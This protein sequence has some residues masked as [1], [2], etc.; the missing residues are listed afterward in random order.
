ME[1]INCIRTRG[2]MSRTTC[3]LRRKKK[4]ASGEYK[5]PEC[6]DCPGPEPLDERKDSQGGTAMK[7][8]ER[9]ESNTGRQDKHQKRPDVFEPCSRCGDKPCNK[10]TWRRKWSGG[11]GLCFPCYDIVRKEEKGEAP[12]AVKKRKSVDPPTTP[13]AAKPPEPKT[14][15]ST[16]EAPQ[17]V[18]DSAVQTFPLGEPG[19]LSVT[20]ATLP[21][22]TAVLLKT[23]QDPEAARYFV[24]TLEDAGVE[25]LVEILVSAVPEEGRI[26]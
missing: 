16:P 13:S 1:M 24:T 18:T 4:G 11:V 20:Y 14:T 5:Y 22:N 19:D 25:V 2:R 26:R 12:P 15:P 23:F 17:D 6:E 8:G 10:N 9:P 21:A 7:Q 3:E